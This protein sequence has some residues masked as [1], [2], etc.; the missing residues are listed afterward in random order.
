MDSHRTVIK[1][2]DYRQEGLPYL[3]EIEF[4]P[5]ADPRSRRAS[6]EAGDLDLAFFDNP[7]L[8]RALVMATDLR[9]FNEVMTPAR[10]AAVGPYRESSRWF[11][12]TDYPSYDPE[13]AKA[14]ITEIEATEG[15]ITVMLGSSGSVSQAEQVQLIAQMWQ[16][17]RVDV[18]IG[19][20]ETAS[21]IID[22]VTGRY[23]SV[24][25]RQFEDPRPRRKRSGGTRPTSM[26]P[27]SSL[28]T[29]SATRTR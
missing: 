29:S 27:V 20:K 14:L 1:H 22:T 9:T 18:E 24:L 28:S 11:A 5:I 10:E 17:A 3:N 16:D 12:P 7:D 21:P 4:R 19:A 6:L 15:E 2:P 13:A 26:I 25:P 8:R 23:E